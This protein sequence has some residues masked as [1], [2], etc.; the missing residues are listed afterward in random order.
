MFRL[1]CNPLSGQY[2]TEELLMQLKTIQKSYRT[3][4]PIPD[5]LAITKKKVKQFGRPQQ[6]VVSLKQHD[7]RI[8]Q[9]RFDVKDCEITL[10]ALKKGKPSIHDIV[11]AEAELKIAQDDLD[12]AVLDKA[13]AVARVTKIGEKK[14]NE[15]LFQSIEDAEDLGEMDVRGVLDDGQRI[16]QF[17][18]QDFAKNAYLLM[19]FFPLGSIEDLMFAKN[20]SKILDVDCKVI[21]VTNGSPEAIKRWI[22]DDN[23]AEGLTII[24]DEDEDSLMGVSNRNVPT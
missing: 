24:S 19:F 11:Q 9:R 15:D 7:K 23:M 16:S 1:E 22:H 5:V 3:G 20:L 8:Q 17:N 21:G 2:D 13:N 12:L 10:E 14:P 18:I 4:V 6:K